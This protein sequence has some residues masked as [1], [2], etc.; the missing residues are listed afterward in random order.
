M[1]TAGGSCNPVVE[2]IG[3]Q[4]ARPRDRPSEVVRGL[5]GVDE[6]EI[7]RGIGDGASEVEGRVRAGAEEVHVGPTGVADVPLGGPD[8]EVDVAVAIHAPGRRRL[9]TQEV[10]RGRSLDAEKGPGGEGQGRRRGERGECH[11]NRQYRVDWQAITVSAHYPLRLSGAARWKTGGAP[12]TLDTREGD[13]VHKTGAIPRSVLENA[14][15]TLQ[16]EC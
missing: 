12:T 7:G 14:P 5:P 9:V 10:P 1:H 8:D 6:G 16:P 13:K 2:P 4:V 15:Y 3:I 11:E